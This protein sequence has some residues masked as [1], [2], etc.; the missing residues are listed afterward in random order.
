MSETNDANPVAA[1]PLPIW[2]FVGV[3]LAVYGVLVVVGGFLPSDRVTV[4]GDTHPSFWWGAIMTVAGVI[5]TAIG[6]AGR[7]GAAA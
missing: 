6:L 7:K 2:F 3:I 1:E 4:M 5:F